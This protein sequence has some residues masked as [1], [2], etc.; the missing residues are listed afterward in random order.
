MIKPLKRGFKM[1]KRS[2]RDPKK[3]PFWKKGWLITLLSLI[4]S[5]LPI[6]VIPFFEPTQEVETEFT[7]ENLTFLDQ[8]LIIIQGNSLFSISEPLNHQ[9]PVPQ[10]IRVVITGYSSSAWETDDDPYI[11]AAGTWVREGIVANNKLPFGTKI[12]IPELFGDKIFVVEDRMSWKK[13]KYHIDIWFPDYWQ[14]L[15]FGA[16]RT[17]IEILEN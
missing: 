9:S 5:G 14:A 3:Q 2:K 13:G 16:K 6:G 15:N 4:I 8:K 10:R 1:R 11:T 12:K 7:F 17:Y